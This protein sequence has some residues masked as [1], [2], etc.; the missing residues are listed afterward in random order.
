M[1]LLIIVEGNNDKVI[2][3]LT[4]NCGKYYFILTSF[5]SLLCL[6]LHSDHMYWS[7]INDK[8]IDSDNM[9]S[10]FITVFSHCYAFFYILIICIVVAN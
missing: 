3:H 8:F 2:H 7:Q 9:F 10:L 4:L 1:C 5:F 6:F